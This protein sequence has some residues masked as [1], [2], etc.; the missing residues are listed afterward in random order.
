LSALH[1]SGT[2][3]FA[4]PRPWFPHGNRIRD[5]ITQDHTMALEEDPI[6]I[7]YSSKHGGSRKREE[8]IYFYPHHEAIM[9]AHKRSE[10]EGKCFTVNQRATFEDPYGSTIRG[11]MPDC[12]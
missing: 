11:K 5:A 2:I 12:W 1:P 7:E 8:K 10:Q 6:L 3:A 4:V 9:V